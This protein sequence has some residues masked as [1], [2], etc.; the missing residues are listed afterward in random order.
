MALG[1][2]PR[3]SASRVGFHTRLKE[4]HN[5]KYQRAFRSELDLYGAVLVG[6]HLDGGSLG[7][8]DVDRTI[9]SRV[10]ILEIRLGGL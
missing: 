9:D 7:S 8:L 2:P 4:A 5:G 10:A 6:R 1:F 3:S